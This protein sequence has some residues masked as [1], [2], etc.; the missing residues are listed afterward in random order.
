MKCM[1]WQTMT[2]ENEIPE[3]KLQ[4]GSKNVET[5]KSDGKSRTNEEHDSES[6]TNSSVERRVNLE[7]FR[8]Y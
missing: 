5:K 2:G 7:A 3:V 8:L 4:E 1:S 6:R